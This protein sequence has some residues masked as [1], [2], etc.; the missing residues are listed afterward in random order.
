MSKKQIKKTTSK[1]AQTRTA[2]ARGTAK[3]SA[4]EPRA[5]SAEA[6]GAE[7]RLPPVGTVIKKLDRH[8]AVR[9]QCTVDEAGIRYKGRVFRSLSGAAMAAATDLGLT[10]KTQNGFTFWGLTKP[11]RKLAD[12]E[13]AL[14]KAWGRFHG[15]AVAQG[16]TDET[17]PQVRTALRA[18]GQALETLLGQVAP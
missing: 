5:R 8:G 12:P 2:R 9:C 3:Q 1:K 7:S 17:R 13:A 15:M 16:A 18:H 6:A 14:N 10:N 11:G 4:T